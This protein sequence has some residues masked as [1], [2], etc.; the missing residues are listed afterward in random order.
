MTGSAAGPIIG[1]SVI[2]PQGTIWLLSWY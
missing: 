1:R 2:Q